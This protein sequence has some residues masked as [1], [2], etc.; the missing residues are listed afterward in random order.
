MRLS[1]NPNNQVYYSGWTNISLIRPNT[2]GNF[3]YISTY[4]NPINIYEYADNF[5]LSNSLQYNKLGNTFYNLI[6]AG[7]TYATL[8]ESRVNTGYDGFIQWIK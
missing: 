6:N 7:S 1:S 4:T 2:I 8:G 5:I 3:A